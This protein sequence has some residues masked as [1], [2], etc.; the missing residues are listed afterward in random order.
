MKNVRDIYFSLC[1]INNEDGY[2]ILVEKNNGQDYI[3]YAKNDNDVIERIKNENVSKLCAIYISNIVSNELLIKLNKITDILIFISPEN[4]VEF[5]NVKYCNQ[6]V[7][8]QNITKPLKNTIK[9]SEYNK[10][11][12]ECFNNLSNKYKS[13]AK[14]IKKLIDMK[15]IEF[16]N[17]DVFFTKYGN[18]IFVDDINKCGEIIIKDS[19]VYNSL[20][21]TIEKNFRGP[22]LGLIDE[23]TK[24][25]INIIPDVQVRN[26]THSKIFKLLDVNTIKNIILYCI[27]HNDFIIRENIEV[28]FTRTSLNI[29]FL[30]SDSS[31]IKNFFEYYF[32][33]KITY[34][35]LYKEC[36]KNKTFITIKKNNKKQI[37]I[38]I[39][40]SENIQEI[41][42]DLDNLD[43]EI[44]Q[45]A[46]NNPN[47]TRKMIDQT[48]NISPRNSNIRIKKMIDKNIF[49]SDGIG[50][51]IRYN[52][53]DDSNY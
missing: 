31:I 12:K 3:F 26:S 16:K 52:F 8:Y 53:N 27:C 4:K 34:D 50:K 1:G 23:V 25:L 43:L 13:N 32:N 44:I 9:L 29:S 35:E 39:F 24:Y 10:Y 11:F 33:Q 17:D 40:L 45:F 18:L 14:A 30:E 20:Y 48:F 49:K 2:M 7:E 22:L 21:F 46:K 41:D 38:R 28:E 6:F 51:A 5:Q 47:F 19:S 42:D 15:I 37:K 36:N